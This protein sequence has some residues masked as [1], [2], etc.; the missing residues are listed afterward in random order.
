MTGRDDLNRRLDEEIRF[1]IEQQVE[2]SLREGMNESEARRAAQLKFGNAESAR[3]Y[4]RDEYRWA[5][6]HDLARDLRIAFRMWNRERGAALVAILTLAIGIG[7]NTAMFSLLHAVVLNPLPNPDVNRLVSIW[8]ASERNPHNEVAYANFADW[9][10]QQH[11]FENLGLYRWWTSNLTGDAAQPERVQ[12]FQLTPDAIKALGLKPHI[13]RWFTT[14]EGEPGKDAVALLGYGLWQRR[15]GGDPRVL[16]QTVRVNDVVRQVI[17]VLPPEMNFPP[18]AEIVAPLRLTPEIRASRRSPSYYA[19][20]RLKPGVTLEDANADI[21][22][23]AA[24][25]EHAYPETNKGLS[26]RVY[27]LSSDVATSYSSGVWLLMGSVGF[28]LLIACA[29][30]ANLLL[31][32]AP[33][34]L[35][36]MAVRV[37]LGASRARIIRQ[38]VAE[39]LALSTIGGGL[40]ALLAAFSVRALRNAAPADVL[41]S[42]PGLANLSVDRSVLLFTFALSVITGLIFGLLPALRTSLVDTNTA[43][44]D[45]SRPLGAAG[46]HRLRTALVAAE[47]ALALILLSGSG[48]TLRAFSRL[49]SM[50]TGFDAD[51]A[52][53]MGITLPYA[54][55]DSESSRLR[56]YE[57][58]LASARALPGVASVGLTSQIPLSPE[59]SSSGLVFEGGDIPDQEPEAD[60]RVVSAGYFETMGA[61]MG[62][63]RPFENTDTIKSPRVMIVNEAFARHFYPNGDAL[64]KRLRFSGPPDQNPWQEIVGVVRNLRHEFSRAPRPE[65]YIPFTQSDEGTLFVVATGRD[66]A[67]GL[68][69]SLR[70]AVAAIDSNQPVWG[71]RTMGEVKHRSMAGFRAMVAFIG[72]FGTIALFLSAV[73]IFGVVSFLVSSRTQEIGLRMAL[74][75]RAA[76]VVRLILAQSATALVAGL[77]IGALGAVAM[78][79]LL[80]STFP[81]MASS[82]PAT[83]AITAALLG[84]VATFATWLPAR[85]AAAVNPT[86]ALRAD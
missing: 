54:K 82:D 30:L 76:D 16:G 38:L 10:A 45:A 27:P 46:G 65:T 83:L 47:V 68:V 26:A 29:N 56:F 59:N 35:R 1:H 53:T 80:A 62:Q 34:R 85:R 51:N 11:S 86:T 55:Y 33:A 67:S 6:L 3:E 61:R 19:I 12:G 71:V 77:L 74:G 79:R 21:A 81:E 24:R 28:V 23:I 72:A 44:R 37:S 75:A 39:S 2:K 69:P 63:G 15:F 43:L 36:E 22:T 58:L 8:D 7:A 40:G 17:G 66:G 32:R 64:G 14:E 4:T 41:V 73:G 20:G 42:V 18:A 9:R 31:A 5:S 84:A 13:G 70:A 49:A 60:F 25:L 57:T 52:V 48:S 50:E 78:G